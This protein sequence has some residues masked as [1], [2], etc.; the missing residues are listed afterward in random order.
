MELAGRIEEEQTVEA[1]QMTEDF[2]VETASTPLCF[3][4][5]CLDLVDH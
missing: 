4:A 3:Y 2:V 1:A 5:V